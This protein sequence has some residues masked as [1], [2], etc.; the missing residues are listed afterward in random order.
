MGWVR[1]AVTV[2]DISRCEGCSEEDW[3]FLALGESS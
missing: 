3:Y 2:A 1:V